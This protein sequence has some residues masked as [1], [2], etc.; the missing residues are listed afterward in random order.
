MIELLKLCGFK[1]QDIGTELPRVEKAFNRLGIT[2]KDIER[3]KQRLSKYYDIELEGVRKALRLCVLELVNSVLAKDEG[4]TKILYGFMA[5]GFEIIGSALVSNSKEVF[6]AHHSW[7]FQLVVGCIFGKI[8]PILEAAEKKWLKAGKVAHCSNV[9][10]ILGL[11]ASDSIPRPDLMVT[12]GFLCET[13]PKTIDLLHELY[14]IPG[15]YYDTCQDR[16]FR[17]YSGATERAV[18]L[19]AKSLRKLVARVQEIVDFEITD[20]MLREVINARNKLGDAVGKLHDLIERSDPLPIS[21]TH[22]TILMCLN[23]LTLS[24]DSLPNAIDAIN[25]LRE[26][27]QERVNKGMGVTEKGAPRIL[28]ILPQHHA[29]PTLEYLVG[30]MGIAIVATDLG[31]FVPYGEAPKDPYLKISTG[32]QISLNTS[33]PRR[34]PLLIDGCKRLNVAGVLDRFHVGCRSVAADAPLIKH[35]IEKELG[36]PVLLLEWENFDPRVHNHEQYKQR[37]EVFKMMLA[38]RASFTAL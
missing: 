14:D 3:G 30:E 6:S 9:K 37:L 20:D 23:S 1:E 7:A 5:P 33:L 22:E 19:A 35:A 17:E 36:I 8:V 16:E 18:A 26:E 2:A 25:T 12:S 10:T 38:K 27:L 31:F 15:C 21:A 4:K 24:I 11:I 32:L 29:D 34:I 28:A 13:A